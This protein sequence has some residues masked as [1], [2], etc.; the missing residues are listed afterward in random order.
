MAPF[1]TKILHDITCKAT[2]N[3]RF[4]HNLEGNCW[5][6]IFTVI[7]RPL[8]SLDILFKDKRF[9]EYATAWVQSKS[10]VEAF[11]FST[12][13]LW[14]LWAIKTIVHMLFSLYTLDYTDECDSVLHENVFAQI[15]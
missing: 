15:R 11:I 6:L 1:T 4:I 12:V 9:H 13:H 5:F 10:F 2:I 3:L 14:A 8:L 7:Y